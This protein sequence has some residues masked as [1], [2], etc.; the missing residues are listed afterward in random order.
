MTGHGSAVRDELEGFAAARAGTLALV[1]GVPQAELDRA[2]PS[3]A[4]RR[5][6][7]PGEILDHLILS[8]GFYRGELEALIRLARSGRPA[9]L[10]RSFSELDI[11]VLFI[12]RAILSLFALPL[13]LATL[14]MPGPLQDFATR[15]R[16]IP[17]Q[18]PTVT[19]PR[20]GRPADELRQEL[21]ASL[22]ATRAVLAA[23]EDL[24]F[25]RMVYQ[26]PLLG[27][28][29]V[30]EMLRFLTLHEQR[31]HEQLTIALAAPGTGEVRAPFPGQV[32]TTERS[33]NERC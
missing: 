19:T 12:P 21:S 18:N 4:G 5:K 14:L 13:T 20:R 28:K 11:S 7:S 6:W 16:L 33:G 25:G 22:A 9:A 26:H 23:N 3:C 8:E 32:S 15:S 2:R 10:T 31:H 27:R 24:D 29:N 30:A 1:A 17:A